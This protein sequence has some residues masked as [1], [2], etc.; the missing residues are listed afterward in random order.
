V[1]VSTFH[2][3]M[4]HLC[5]QNLCVQAVR[6]GA[7]RE[8]PQRVCRKKRGPKLHNL[9]VNA[10]TLLSLSLAMFEDA[11]AAIGTKLEFTPCTLAEFREFAQSSTRKIT[12][13][14]WGG[15]RLHVRECA[16][17]TTKVYVNV[18]LS[19]CAWVC[20]CAWKCASA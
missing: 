11:P 8:E 4:H 1:Y 2:S 14:V 7:A 15:D 10:A 18:S 20:A 9:A 13:L 19:A 17:A 12:K 6:S 5:P 3:A 16:S